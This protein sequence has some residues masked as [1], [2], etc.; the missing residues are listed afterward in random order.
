MLAKNY[1]HRTI[2]DLVRTMS[3]WLKKLISGGGGGGVAIRMSLDAFFEKNKYSGRGV[4]S[5]L[6][7]M[8]NN[9]SC[10]LQTRFEG[11]Q[12][13]SKTKSRIT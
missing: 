3:L 1:F 10:E 9:L 12:F 4:Y 7:S 8:Y 13:G 5:G 6:E 2:L 11:F